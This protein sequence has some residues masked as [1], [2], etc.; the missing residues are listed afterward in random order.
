MKY[1]EVIELNVKKYM[2]VKFAAEFWNMNPKTISK[3]CAQGKICEA[4]KYRD[5]KWYIPVDAVKPLSN[6]EIRKFLIL[7]IQLKNKPSLEI[8]RSKFSTEMSTIDNIYHYL[9]S[10]EFIENFK[11]TDKK[12]IPY[13]VILTQKGLEFATSNIKMKDYSTAL[14]EWLPTIIGVAQLITQVSQMIIA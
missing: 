9:V 12:R 7:T 4:T 8:D 6:D 5:R 11:I 3:Y 2:S 14:K 13:D 1:Q 10:Q